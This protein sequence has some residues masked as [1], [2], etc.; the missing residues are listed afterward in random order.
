MMTAELKTLFEPRSVALVGASKL[1][2]EDKVYSTLFHYLVQNLASFKKGKVH[3]VDLDG[4]I[5]GSYK[6]ISKLQKGQDL[7]VVLLPKKLL[8]KNLQK[9]LTCQIRSLVMIEGRLEETEIAELAAAARRKKM[10]LLGPNSIG[11]INTANELF[12]I[13]ERMHIRKGHVGLI[14]QDCCVAYG[15]LDLAKAAGISKM[16]S[17]SDSIGT[18]ESDVLSYFSRDKETKAVCIYIKK[19]RDG[20]KLVKAIQETVP[21][22]PV[23]ILNGGAERPRIFEAAVRQAGAILAHDVQDMLNG[24]SGL[25]RQPPLRGPRIAIVTNLV[26]QA[27][28]FERYLFEEGLSLARPADEV[29]QKIKK[30]YPSAEISAFIN[31]GAAAKA[32]AYKSVVEL[33]LSDESVDGV[34]IINSLKSTLF[35]VEDLRE[36]ASV[37]KKSKEKPVIAT[38][39]CA[40]DNQAV[41]EI[42]SS[43]EL[44]I[45]DQLEEAAHVLNMLLIR[46]KQLEKINNARKP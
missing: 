18:E 24:A 14:S 32:D 8:Y 45:Y 44:P 15:A 27:A 46:G 37:A 31:L 29:G 16:A 23:I 11:S 25:V 35:N 6:S 7:A 9:L 33:L 13:P 40:E 21:E 5:E 4:E 30:K 43:T 10:A 28:L 2:K 26:G 36:V 20:R 39:L 41:K 3:V 19:V 1:E 17:I 12:A 22:K 38:V 34:I 42:I